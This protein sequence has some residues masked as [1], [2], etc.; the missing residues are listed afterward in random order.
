MSTIT[1]D[2]PATE[3]QRPKPPQTVWVTVAL[4]LSVVAL[5]LSGLSLGALAQASGERD[6]L[7]IRLACLELPGPNDCGQDGK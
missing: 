6:E 5:L 7:Q 2:L 4:L 3:L 1:E